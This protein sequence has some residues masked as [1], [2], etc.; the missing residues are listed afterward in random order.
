MTKGRDETMAEAQL[1]RRARDGWQAAVAPSE[2]PD[3]LLLAGYLDGALEPAVRERVEAW[4]AGSP[5]ALDLALAARAALTE[6]AN[7]PAPEALVARAQ[8]LVRAPRVG[9][10]TGSLGER[11]LAQLADVLRPA[12]WAGAAALLLLTALGG[13]EL[14]RLGGQQLAVS[15]G[16]A[17]DEQP[18]EYVGLW[19]D[20]SGDELL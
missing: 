14:G 2:A 12:V 3:P 15:D 13:F 4:L 8:G 11:L 7:P 18:I 17:S 19:L 20:Q 9:A 6:R 1:W 16:A 5:E 10:A